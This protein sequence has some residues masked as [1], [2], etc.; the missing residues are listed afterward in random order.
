MTGAEAVEVGLVVDAG[1]GLSLRT[2]L[3]ARAGSTLEA[4]A[5]D[6]RPYELD[7]TLLAVGKTPP[8]MVGA[9]SIGAFM[10]AQMTHQ[11]ERLQASKA[12]G[13]AAALV[14]LTT[15]SRRRSAGQTGFRARL[16]EGGGRRCLRGSWRT[17]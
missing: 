15:R 13:A 11:R 3:R 5:K 12:K 4:L 2:R 8:A 10:R 9:S 14:V 16:L 1:K 7:G 6:V 17:R